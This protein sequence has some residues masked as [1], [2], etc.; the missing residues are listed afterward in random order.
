MEITIGLRFIQLVLIQNRYPI[1]DEDNAN[2][3]LCVVLTPGKY[4]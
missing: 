1:F 2:Q 4:K 3:V